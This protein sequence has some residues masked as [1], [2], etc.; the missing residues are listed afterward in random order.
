[1]DYSLLR[2][3]GKEITYSYEENQDQ[4]HQY[5]THLADQISGLLNVKNEESK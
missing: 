4:I 2:Y 3:L 1:M 5:L